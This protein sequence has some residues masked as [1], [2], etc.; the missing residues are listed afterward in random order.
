MIIESGNYYVYKH[1]APNG[2]IYI[3]ITKSNPILRWKNGKGYR[4]QVFYRAI[5]K[6]GWDNIKHEI[7]YN[8]LTKEDAEIIERK[9]IKEYKAN[10][11]QYGYNVD[12]GGN[13]IGTHSQITREKLSQYMKGDTRNKG[14]KHTLESRQNMSNA[15]KGKHL[16]EQTKKKLSISL[17]GRIHSDE[18]IQKLKQNARQNFSYPVYCMELD[19]QFNSV[20]E[21]VEYIKS[22]GGSIYSSGLRRN[23]NG[24]LKKSGRLSDGSYLHWVKSLD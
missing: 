1:T 5:L 17:K 12:N 3:G 23:V 11:P 21:A 15:H 7:L 18:A 6:Y 4:T 20:P 16:S 19:M 10:N 2:K 9:L 24:E 8:N 22:I 13:S 14:R